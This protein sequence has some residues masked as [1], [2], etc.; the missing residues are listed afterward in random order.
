M[1]PRPHAAAVRL[2]SEFPRASEP[3]SLFRPEELFSPSRNKRY[4]RAHQHHSDPPRRAH[5][6][7]QNIF[8]AQ[9]A[10][11]VA[12]RRSWN[13]KTYRLPRQQHQ[14]RIERSA[15][16]GRPAQNHPLRSA[17]RRN[18]HRSRGRR[19]AGSPVA[20]IPCVIAISP[21]VLPRISTATSSATRVMPPPVALPPP[22]RAAPSP[23]QSTP[24]HKSHPPPPPPP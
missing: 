18:A 2:H 12:Q 17:R 15:I 7:A 19:R 13:H 20:F 21:P 14:Q 1:F 5:L 23:P 22:S 24:H 16:S 6:L 11:H 3:G 4:S 8:R 9:R 10:H